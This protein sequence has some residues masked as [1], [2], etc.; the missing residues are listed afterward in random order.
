M[1]ST[2]TAPE[3]VNTVQAPTGSQPSGGM[4]CLECGDYSCCCIPC[5]IMKKPVMPKE[6]K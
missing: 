6:R 2:T 4:P 5:T 1:K 3:L